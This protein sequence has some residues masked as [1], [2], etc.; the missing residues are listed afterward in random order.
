MT[1]QKIQKLELELGGI[2]EE[3]GGLD[4]PQA[5]S[6]IAK[7]EIERGLNPDKIHDNLT[8]KYG[9]YRYFNNLMD[10]YSRKVISLDI[11][12]ALQ[13]LEDYK[14]KMV[15]ENQKHY[16]PIIHSLYKRVGEIA[17]QCLGKTK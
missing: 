2:Y 15:A 3:F 11:T 10:E 7:I 17:L 4:N 1:E 14:H 16:L 6:L 13:I 8:R 5:R 12:G 9:P